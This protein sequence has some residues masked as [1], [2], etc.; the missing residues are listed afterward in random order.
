MT[1]EASIRSYRSHSRVP[2]RPSRVPAADV[3]TCCDQRNAASIEAQAVA[4]AGHI[5][6]DIVIRCLT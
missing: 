6:R 3:R 4:V 2:R 5:C 1:S